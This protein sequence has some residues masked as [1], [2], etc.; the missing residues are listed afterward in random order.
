MFVDTT[1][2]LR[3]KIRLSK[4]IHFLHLFKYADDATKVFHV[5]LQFLETKYWKNPQKQYRSGRKHNRCILTSMYPDLMDHI[6]LIVRML[7]NVSIA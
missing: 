1:H 4:G 5:N 2:V 3:T 6:S 7:L